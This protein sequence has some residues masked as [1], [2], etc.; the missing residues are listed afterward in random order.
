MYP[1]LSTRILLWGSLYPV[2]H[3][4]CIDVWKADVLTTL[5]IFTANQQPVNRT[6]ACLAK[7]LYF[8]DYTR[9]RYL[10]PG[11]FT[12]LLMRVPL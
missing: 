12:V 5:I 3:G 6:Q 4:R 11:L 7:K 10:Y 9:H 1:I 2:Q 8:W